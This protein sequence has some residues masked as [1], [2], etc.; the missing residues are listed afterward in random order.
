M[1]AQK[2]CGKL[3][4]A[5]VDR[6][7]G[8]PLHNTCGFTIMGETYL[9]PKCEAQ[10][11]SPSGKVSKPVEPITT[12]KEMGPNHSRPLVDT[13]EDKSLD[14]S[15]EENSQST[16][17]THSQQGKSYTCQKD[18]LA[19]LQPAGTHSHLRKGREKE[20]GKEY[21]KNNK[22]KYKRT[23]E[24]ELEKNPDYDKEHY[25]QQKNNESYKIAHR[26]ATAKYNKNN[27]E[28]L[29]AKTLAQTHIK[30]EGDCERCEKVPA[31]HRHHPDY[32]KPLYV[33]LVCNKCH[34]EIHKNG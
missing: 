32:S 12:L 8:Y 2:G 18:S 23:R 3:V 6:I 16:S 11:H 14:T 5:G 21:Y 15:Q 9:C 1:N 22:D 28:I 7:D 20:Y 29:R 17:G 4:P 10:N 34:R 27:P 31:Q 13:P 25:Q 26:K 30:L 24:K 33:Q 19:N